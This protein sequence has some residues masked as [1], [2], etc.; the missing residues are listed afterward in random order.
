[1]G[2]SKFRCGGSLR[3]ATKPKLKVT[4]E[5]EIDP[6]EIETKDNQFVLIALTVLVVAFGYFAFLA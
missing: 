6:A 1:M 5:P 3:A 4:D 2:W